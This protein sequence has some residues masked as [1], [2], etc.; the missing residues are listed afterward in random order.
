MINR[1]FI[2][3][4]EVMYEVIS[5]ISANNFTNSDG[6]I[7]QQVLGQYVHELKGDRVLQRDHN[8]LIC[9]VVEEATIIPK[10]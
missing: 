3:R 8:L 1:E 9:Q 5:T 10:Q 7:N 6:S 4:D 2:T